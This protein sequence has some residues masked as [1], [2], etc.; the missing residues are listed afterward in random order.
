M[1]IKDILA[2][3]LKGEALTD[4][5]KAFAEAFD[6]QGELDKASASARRKAEA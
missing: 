6:L 4:E 2:K 1:N 5:E 3:L